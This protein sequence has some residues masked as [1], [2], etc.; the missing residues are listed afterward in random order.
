VPAHLEK[1]AL[2][3]APRFP[4]AISSRAMERRMDL[5]DSVGAGVRGGAE[6]AAQAAPWIE[7][8]ARVG[9]AA[10]GVLYA[11]VGFLAAQA[12]LGRGGRTTDSRGALKEV[13][14]APYGRALLG[15]VALGL[16]G[17]ALWRLVQAVTDPERKGTDA[18]GLSLRA[19]YVFR[20]LVH[21]ALAVSAARLAL[22]QGSDGG[23]RDGSEVWTARLLEAPGGAWL[24]WLAAAGV[25][26][27][28]LYQLYRAYEAKLG[29]QLAIGQLPPGTAHWVVFVSRF[30]IA[31]RGIVFGLIGVLLARAAASGNAA[32]AGGIRDSLRELGRMGRWPLVVG[33]VGLIAYGI[34]ELVNSR[35][36]RI[37]A[38]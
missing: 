4:Q 17:Y 33:G 20:G 8:L 11:T 14:G 13:L 2:G 38:G 15:V 28:G 22:G 23:G 19:S 25:I 16:A 34:Y 30:G 37:R 21:G 9:Y 32:Q 6:M 35:Y 5:T 27:F 24:V 10:K 26:G 1:S 12:A 29:R 3:T 36:R 18:K 31:A 7:G